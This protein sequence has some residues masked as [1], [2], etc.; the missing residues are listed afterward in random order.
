MSERISIV[1]CRSLAAVQ[2]P[3]VRRDAHA[4]VAREPL[5]RQ[6]AQARVPVV[7]REQGRLLERGALDAPIPALER[8]VELARVDRHE[9]RRRRVLRLV[10]LGRGGG[11]RRRRARLRARRAP[12]ERRLEL[13]LALLLP[14]EPRLERGDLALELARRGPGALRLRRGV[15]RPRRRERRLGPLARALRRLRRR[16]ARGPP[17][18]PPG[19]RG[20]APP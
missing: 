14:R 11:R 15:G 13:P 4:V 2:Q 10:R 9:P 17:R 7:L 12:R 19:P 1:F 20:R 16:P 8:V 18:P 6:R 3:D 5:E